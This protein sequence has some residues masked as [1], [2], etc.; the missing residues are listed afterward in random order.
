M[1]TEGQK[2]RTCTNLLDALDTTET[3]TL[4]RLVMSSFGQRYM[5]VVERLSPPSRVGS[6]DFFAF[7]VRIHWVKKSCSNASALGAVRRTGR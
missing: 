6:N 3:C 5:P 4:P 2:M 7:A 1:G